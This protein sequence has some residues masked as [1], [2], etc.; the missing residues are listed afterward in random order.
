MAKRIQVATT[1]SGHRALHKANGDQSSI[2]ESYAT[3]SKP[4]E[5]SARNDGPTQGSKAGNAAD[6]ASKPKSDA[7]KVAYVNTYSML[8]KILTITMLFFMF[9]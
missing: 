3:T 8:N 1:H 2:T 5:S 9:G 6:G 4:S 7:Q